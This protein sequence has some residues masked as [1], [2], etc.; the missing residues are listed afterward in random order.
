V[1]HRDVRTVLAPGSGDGTSLL[2][3]SGSCAARSG[4]ARVLLARIEP[5]PKEG[6]YAAGKVDEDGFGLHLAYSITARDALPHFDYPGVKEL[7]QSNELEIR[8][9]PGTHWLNYP[10]EVRLVGGVGLWLVDL[11]LIEADR[12]KTHWHWLLR[13]VQKGKAVTVPSHHSMVGSCSGTVTMATWLETAVNL[14]TTPVP[15]QGPLTVTDGGPKWVFSGWY[16]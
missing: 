10:G 1:Q 7:D 4:G 3:R 9:G 15:V 5:A 13:L 12:P 16:G 6:G 14:T 8:L 2:V 11:Q